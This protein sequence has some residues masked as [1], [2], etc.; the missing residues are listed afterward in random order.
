L[1]EPRGF[2][3]IV[4]GVELADQAVDRPTV[5]TAS[6]GPRFEVKEDGR[7][8]DKGEP[9]SLAR[10]QHGLGQMDR[11]IE[12]VLQIVRGQEE[13][14]ASGTIVMECRLPVM[15]LQREFVL[16]NSLA[17]SA[18][19]VIHLTMIFEVF[20]VAKGLVAILTILALPDSEVLFQVSP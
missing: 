7:A 2:G 17:L 13:L 15:L 6:A 1:E 14:L 11:R 8:R 16:E 3:D 4:V 19:R 12:V 20:R 18:V 9:T 5:C 10:A